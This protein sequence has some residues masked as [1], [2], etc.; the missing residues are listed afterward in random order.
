M[1]N[2]DKCGKELR[3]YDQT[4]SIS[5]TLKCICF[6]CYT[7]NDYSILK[8]KKDVDPVN[9]NHYKGDLVA[10]IIERFELG[11]N[12]GNVIKY[13]LRYK[14]KN[15]IE[16]L[17]KAKWYLEREIALLEEDPSIEILK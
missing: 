13:T 11:F 14:N 2:C 5:E 17:K 12:L 8:T 6:E 10:R 1:D 7:F 9:P 4:Y 16:D 15:G 3:E